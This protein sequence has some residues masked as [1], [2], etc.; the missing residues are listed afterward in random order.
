MNKST[1]IRTILMASLL[2]TSVLLAGCG[3]GGWANDSSKGSV[4][5]NLKVPRAAESAH[6]RDFTAAVTVSSICSGGVATVVASSTVAISQTCTYGEGGSSCTQTGGDFFIT[7]I[8]AGNNYLVKSQLVMTSTSSP[9]RSTNETTT[10]TYTAYMGAIVG[11]ITG[12]VT[13][14]IDIDGASTVTALAVMRYAEIKGVALSDT[15]VVT[16]TVKSAIATYVANAIKNQTIYPGT[17]E[18]IY[19][20]GYLDPFDRANWTAD[21]R[22]QLDAILGGAAAP[23]GLSFIQGSFCTNNG[24]FFT[25]KNQID[26]NLLGSASWT[27]LANSMNITIPSKTMDVSS[28]TP[29]AIFNVSSEGRY[30]ALSQNGYVMADV[31]T[32]S[33]LGPLCLDIAIRK[34]TAASLSTISGNFIAYELRSESDYVDSRVETGSTLVT[35]NG[36]G[37]GTY[38]ELSSSSTGTEVDSGTF[39]YTVNADGTIT[40]VDPE[41]GTDYGIISPDGNMFMM[42]DT[43]ASDTDVALI[44]AFKK[45]SA[46]AASSMV[47]TFHLF[48][49][50]ADKE[51]TPDIYWYPDTEYGTFAITTPGSG[52]YTTISNSNSNTG[53]NTASYTGN[54]DGTFS[55]TGDDAIGIVFPDSSMLLMVDS[56]LTEDNYINFAIGIKATQQ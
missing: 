55:I 38:Q 45:S 48:Q 42:F 36:A 56:V 7:N 12:G 40:V 37:S 11:S 25:L 24:N 20:N 23:G 41:E 6:T 32:N 47:G 54:A 26:V 17:F 49:F 14:P 13:T 10:P 21:F 2:A 52:L 53:S 30:G 51:I 31:S 35:L 44:V 33:G 28:I 9:T 50:G 39:T 27:N 43:D 15:S 1:T 46:M 18:T 8:P 29:G 16:D 5:L 4:R 22:T 34:S 19:S 3:G